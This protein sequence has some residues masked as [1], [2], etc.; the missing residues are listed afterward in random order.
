[1][2]WGEIIVTAGGVVSTSWV[3][4]VMLMTFESLVPV[5]V[6]TLIMK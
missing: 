3:G 1:M 2:F 5:V 4:M 6:Y